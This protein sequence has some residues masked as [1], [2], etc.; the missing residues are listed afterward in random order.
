MNKFTEYKP[1]EPLCHL[2]EKFVISENA[3]EAVYNVLPQPSLVMGFQYRGR[4]SLVD[5]TREAT[6]G[7]AG[8]TGLSSRYRTFKNVKNTG[9]VLVYF[10][11]G[12]IPAILKVPAHELFGQ[13]VP[14]TAFFPQDEVH[15]LEESLFGCETDQEKIGAVGNFLLARLRPVVPDLLVEHALQLIYSSKGTIRIQ[16]LKNKLNISESPLEKRFRAAVG[17]PAKKFILTVRLQNLMKRRRSFTSLTELALDAGYFDQSHFIK[18]FKAFAG[19]TP[20]QFFS[21]DT[22]E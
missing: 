16:E 21:S 14:L 19:S 20:E 10:R 7:T 11:P 18:Q 2:V 13:S 4:L 15:S 12:A 6:L 5:E 8:I 9:T 3:V 22:G 17:S 1:P